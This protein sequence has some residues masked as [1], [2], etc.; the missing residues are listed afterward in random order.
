MSSI[1]KP[2]G[3]SPFSEEELTELVRGIDPDTSEVTWWYAQTLD[4]YGIDRDLPKELQQIGREYFVQSLPKEIWVWFG[5]L[6]SELKDKLWA[7]HKHELAFPAGLELDDVSDYKSWKSNDSDGFD[8]A[9]AAPLA[10]AFKEAIADERVQKHL[11]QRKLMAAFAAAF[12][13]LLGLKNSNFR[14]DDPSFM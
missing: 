4:P 5:D 1:V 13:R 2:S 10:E 6:P 14:H 9:D 3:Y 11:R 7:K 12:N 8:G